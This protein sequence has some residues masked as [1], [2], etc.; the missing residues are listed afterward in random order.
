MYDAFLTGISREVGWEGGESKKN[1]FCGGGMDNFWNHTLQFNEIKN[2]ILFK[3]L[4]LL[5]L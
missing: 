3:C 4:I 5:V 1:A 2:F